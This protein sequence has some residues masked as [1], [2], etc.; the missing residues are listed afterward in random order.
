M[1]DCAKSLLVRT[2][3]RPGASERLNLPKLRT[4]A[5]V[6]LEGLERADERPFFPFRTQARINRCDD[7]FGTWDGKNGDEI[8][9]RA[10]II[11]DK[12]EIEIGG[13]GQLAAP[14][15]S[16]RDDRQIVRAHNCSRG[17]KTSF[18][19]VCNFLH[20]IWQGAEP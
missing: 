15:F 16:H 6:G 12:H 13:I 9:C 20:M 10:K 4:I 3:Y 11:A 5:I 7:T 2:G 17:E 19:E 14:E 8:L 18:R 1:R